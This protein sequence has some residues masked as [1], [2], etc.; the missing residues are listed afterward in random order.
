MVIKRKFPNLVPC[1]LP[2]LTAISRD[3]DPFTLNLMRRQLRKAIT[4]AIES[5]EAPDVT[6]AVLLLNTLLKSMDSNDTGSV[7]QVDGAQ[8][9]VPALN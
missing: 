3:K 1:G 2:P 9:L 7:R 8:D 4:I 5:V 6:R